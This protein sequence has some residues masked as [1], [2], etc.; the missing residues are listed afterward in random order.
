MMKTLLSLCSIVLVVLSSG[1]A[2]WVALNQPGPTDDE[3]V[4]V[5]MHR[6]EVESVLRTGGSA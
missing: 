6:A 5:G 4:T 3:F 2:S 1:C